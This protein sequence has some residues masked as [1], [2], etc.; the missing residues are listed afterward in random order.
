M[1][2][3]RRLREDVPA[4]I[5]EAVRRQTGF[6]PAALHPVFLLP[7]T[8]PERRDHAADDADDALYQG[9][10]PAVPRGRIGGK[11]IKYEYCIFYIFPSRTEKN[12]KKSAFFLEMD[13]KN[14]E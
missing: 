6:R 2:R 7:G 8:L 5:P 3:M 4:E 9:G 12:R 14:M 1:R 13:W 11:Q 10:R